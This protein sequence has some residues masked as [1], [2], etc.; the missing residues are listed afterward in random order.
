[1]RLCVLLSGGKDSNYTL[2]KAILENHEIVCIVIVKPRKE[3]SWLFH[4]IYPEIAIL[5]AHAM[6]LQ[7]KAYVIEV[8][9]EK[10]LE[11]LEFE[12]QLYELK[13]LREFDAIALGVI[14][15]RYQLTRFEKIAKSLNLML[16][17]PLWSIDQYYYMRKLVEEGFVFIITK[18]STMGLTRDFLFKPI[19]LEHVE[20]IILL[21]RIYGF[22]PS[23]DG[24]E[25]ETLVI[26][27]PHYKYKICIEGDTESRSEF[28]HIVKI[29]RYWLSEK[30]STNCIMNIG[31]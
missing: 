14:L 10:E 6:G 15:S 27:A 19:T 18:I 31:S 9:G 16:Y 17:T 3:D 4:S 25:A 12:R 29:R 7:D 21:S 11:L 28:E 2:Y 23:F 30:D 24:G 20:K 26:D 8:S 5:Q 1:M 13:N 22:N